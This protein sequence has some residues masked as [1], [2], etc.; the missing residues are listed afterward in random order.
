MRLAAVILAAGYSSRMSGFKPLMELGGQSLVSCCAGVFRRAGV[1]DIV[2]VTGYR[3][4]EVEAEAARLGLSCIYNPD[5][6]RGMYSS[7]IAAAP[8]LS[9]VDGFF[10]LP[11][12][13]SLIRPATI[14]ALSAAF[15][16]KAVMYP[17][18]AGLRGHPPL[19]PAQLIPAILAH[20]GK[21][22]LKSVLKRQDGREIAVWD[23]GVLLDADTPEDFAVQA[24]RVG[25]MAIGDADEALALA[26]LT[27]PER[28][29]AHGL[30]VA[31]VARTLGQALNRHGY[32]LDLD[33]VNNAA[34]LHDI[35]KGQPQHEVRGAEMLND[36]GLA[37]LAEIVAVHRDIPPPASRLLTEKEVVC[38]AD[39]L[40]RGAKRLPVRQRFAEK[41]E[42]YAA[43][44]E[45]CRAIEGRLN[46]A[47]ALQS[48]V[49][50]AVGQRI[51]KILG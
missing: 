50:Q 7:V 11:V 29:L 27:L 15:D 31:A 48:L 32:R 5:Y 16:G 37:K 51:N 4:E 3:H 39:K 20:D 40:V 47:L 17:C 33:L 30:A 36:L 24:Q 22:G 14:A 49:E 43:D 12:D 21:G 41:L 42:L 38:L 46:N 18:F 6:D 35:A 45:A 26:R 9:E 2:L 1:G 44:R 19:I 28:G 8:H 10:V 23:H 34:L 13:I 25:R